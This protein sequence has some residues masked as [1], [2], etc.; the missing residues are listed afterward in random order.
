MLNLGF[1]FSLQQWAII[2]VVSRFAIEDAIGAF[3][4]AD[5][6]RFLLFDGSIKEAA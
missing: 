2:S 1:I 3:S 6:L 4:A 5:I